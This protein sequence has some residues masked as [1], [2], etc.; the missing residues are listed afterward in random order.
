M[1]VPGWWAGDKYRF[2]LVSYEKISVDR[3]NGDPDAPHAQAMLAAFAW[4]SS[5]AAYLQN[6]TAH[7]LLSQLVSTDGR[8]FNI[9]VFQLGRDRNVLWGGSSAPL[10]GEIRSRIIDFNPE[11]IVN[12]L[13]LYANASNSLSSDSIEPAKTVSDLAD[14]E[15]RE[16]V[17]RQHRHL[18]SGRPRH[19]L[20]PEVYH[21][22]KI[23][24]IDHNS[25]P[26]EP[27]R[28]PFE[29][30][31]NPWRRKLDDW[32]NEYI[33]KALREEKSKVKFRNKYY[34]K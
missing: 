18:T 10:F 23:Y 26:M 24:K 32:S 29:L 13:R 12:I 19:R 5:Q 21:W 15:Q 16:W 31:V 28:R 4:T 20:P 33:P 27:R 22:E 25:R 3:S 17:Y 30:G 2:G 7:P 1:T 9:Y 11:V 6:P 14:A 8:N 34:P